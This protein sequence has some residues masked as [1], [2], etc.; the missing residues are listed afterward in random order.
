[1]ACRQRVRVDKTVAV[2]LPPENK[3]VTEVIHKLIGAEYSKNVEKKVMGSM[4]FSMWV[5]DRCQFVSAMN[6]KEV[7]DKMPTQLKLQGKP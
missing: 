4:A 2:T 7:E 5:Q 6:I 3:E 1:M